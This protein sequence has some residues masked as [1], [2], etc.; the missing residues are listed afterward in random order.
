[1]VVSRNLLY[2]YS[3]L[4]GCALHVLK[5]TTFCNVSYSSAAPEVCELD[6]L[7]KLVVEMFRLCLDKKTMVLSRSRSL[8]PG[9][10]D[11]VCSFAVLVQNF[12]CEDYKSLSEDCW[13][14]DSGVWVVGL[15]FHPL[16][17]DVVV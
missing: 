6:E 12:P 8:P 1:M 3:K 5:I 16:K 15:D 14:S 13:S 10:W 4:N 17:K 9:K 11:G 2:G 7:G